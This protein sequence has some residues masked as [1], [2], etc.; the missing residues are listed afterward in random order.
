MLKALHRGIWWLLLC[1]LAVGQ[2][3]RETQASVANMVYCSRYLS[4]VVTDPT[5]APLPNAKVQVRKGD[6][7]VANANTDRNGT[8]L[9][10]K[11]NTGEYELAVQ[12]SA[13]NPAR[14]HVVVK[15][16][17][18]RDEPLRIKMRLAP[19]PHNIEVTQFATSR[20]RT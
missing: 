11:L 14:Y 8:F 19:L 2:Q 18:K 5:G 17:G 16:S 4:G 13:F 10:K 9:F 3:S 20:S 15:E 7:E 1:G 6:V 12:A